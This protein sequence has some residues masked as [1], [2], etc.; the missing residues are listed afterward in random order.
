MVNI[1]CL[2][3]FVLVSL[4]ADF[5]V[6]AASPEAEFLKGRYVWVNWDIEE[7][8]ARKE[9]LVEKNLLTMGLRG[10]PADV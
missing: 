3:V 10:W 6:W 4:P 7:L 2:Q 9:E 5:V 1:A 8:K